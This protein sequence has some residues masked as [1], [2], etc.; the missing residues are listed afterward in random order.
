MPVAPGS[1]APSAEILALERDP[2][3]LALAVLGAAVAP[4][5]LAARG[6]A[7]LFFY[8]ATVA[9]ATPPRTSCRAS[10]ACRVSP[11][12]RSRRTP[13]STRPSSRAPIGSR[14]AACTSSS[15]RSPGPRRTRSASSRRPPSCSL[16]PGARVAAVL[17]GWSR[18]DANALAARA[19]ALAGAL[20]PSSRRAAD[21]P[22]SVPAEARAT[23]PR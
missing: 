10:R 20:P 11:S 21:G 8:K 14:R 19:A 9:R 5:A 4:R 7:L 1:L 17:E 13:P 16:A 15:T 3:D 22:P 12:P 18:D 6:P 2:E 23:R